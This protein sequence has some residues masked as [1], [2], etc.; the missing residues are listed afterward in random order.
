MTAEAAD[1]A[2]RLPETIQGR[3]RDLLV[4]LEAWPNV[5]GAKRLRGPLSGQWRMRTGDYRIQFVLGEGQVVV[6][7]IG[8][9]HRFYE[10][11]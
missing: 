4:R 10:G 9:R 5:S 1:E 6:V 7:K 8:H 11:R 3:I 2:S